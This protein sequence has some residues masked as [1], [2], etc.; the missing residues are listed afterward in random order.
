M[1]VLQ[2]AGFARPRSPLNSSKAQSVAGMQA[3][4]AELQ[5][6]PPAHSTLCFL[7]PYLAAQRVC[8]LALLAYIVFQRENCIFLATVCLTHKD[9]MSLVLLKANVTQ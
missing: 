9:V 5:A 6:V 3:Q 2:K 7:L 4:G 1:P 8:S